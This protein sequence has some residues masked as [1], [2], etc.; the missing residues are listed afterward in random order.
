MHLVVALTKHWSIDHSIVIG[1]LLITN[2]RQ[3]CPTGINFFIPAQI[4]YFKIIFESLKVFRYLSKYLSLVNI[5]FKALNDQTRRDILE[6]LQQKDMT[7]GEI[8]DQFHISFPSISHHLELLRRA[9]LVRSQ[10]SG[11]YVIYSLNT[12][13]VDEIIKWMMQFTNKNSSK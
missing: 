12:T 5:V 3:V 6:H 9:D 10:K 11:Q 13:V 7:A 1:C 8:A 4:F 2:P